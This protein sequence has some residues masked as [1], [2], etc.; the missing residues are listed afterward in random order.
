MTIVRVLAVVIAILTGAVDASAQSSLT[1]GD[2]FVVDSKV[3]G[4]QRRVIVWTPPGYAVG[5]QAYPVLYLTD[6]DRQFGHTVTTVEFLSRN[7]RMPPMIVVGVFNTDR[8]RDLTPYKDSD[9]DTQLPTAGGAD[10]FLRFVDTELVPWVQREYRTQ[11]FRAFAGHSF[12]GLFALHTLA[13]RPDLFNA[14]VAVSPSLPWRQGEAVKRIDTMLAQQRTLKC[15]LYVTLGD[16]GAAM[17]A[18]LDRL[19]TVLEEKAGKNLRW[20]LVEMLDEDHGSIVLRSHYN[21][22]EKIFEGWRL[23]RTRNGTFKGGM[24]AVEAHYAKLSD[25]LGWA[26]TPPEATINALGYATLAEHQVDEALEY[27]QANA[28]NYPDSA[29]AYD[30]LG[31]AL[32]AAG[33]LDEALTKYEEAIR[34]GEAERI[35]SSTRSA[36]IATRCAR[37]WRSTAEECIAKFADG[38]VLSPDSHVLASA[39]AGCAPGG[40]VRRTTI[41]NFATHSNDVRSPAEH[42]QSVAAGQPARRAAPS[43]LITSGRSTRRVMCSPTPSPSA[44]ERLRSTR[45]GRLAWIAVACALLCPSAVTGQT[46]STATG[47]IAGTVTCQ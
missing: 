19:R 20:D 18:G 11:G 44:L 25:R 6:A 23:P 42:A 40:R 4:E 17:K 14:I 13:T 1:V 41:V 12:G 28:R 8:T 43:N 30:S 24:K 2:L 26:I 35:R 32:E 16:E 34:R 3:M 45:I 21:G 38:R 31:E 5:S 10:R 29:N 39:R 36:R 46:V 27:L 47:V 9:S 22:L 37:S 15:S 33:R 7:G